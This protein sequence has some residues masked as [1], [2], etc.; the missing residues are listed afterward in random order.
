[1]QKIRVYTLLLTYHIEGKFMTEYFPT[2][3][4]IF[5]VW[6]GNRTYLLEAEYMKT[7]NKIYKK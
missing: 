5:I 4:K 6:T 2:G 1:M 3:D 7:G